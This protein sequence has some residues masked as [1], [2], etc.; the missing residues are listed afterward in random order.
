MRFALAKQPLV[1]QVLAGSE[2]GMAAQDVL[3]IVLEGPA[4]ARTQV[5]EGGTG[6]AA[7]GEGQAGRQL[8]VIRQVDAV[9]GADRKAKH[10]AEQWPS[11]VSAFDPSARSLR[12]LKLTQRDL[13]TAEPRCKTDEEA[14]RDAM[15]KALAARDPDALVVIPA[16]A[17]KHGEFFTRSLAW[18]ERERYTFAP[19]LATVNAFDPRDDR[20]GPLKAA[21]QSAATNRLVA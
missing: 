11:Y 20:W 9:K 13:D 18:M 19:H 6:F 12:T 16:L 10:I 4:A 2:Q 7:E 15:K 21:M 3:A 5:A 17:Q 8:R 14:L 1:D